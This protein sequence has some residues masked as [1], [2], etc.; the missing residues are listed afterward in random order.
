[1]NATP[2]GLSRRRL[3]WRSAG[4]VTALCLGACDVL[5]SQQISVAAHDWIGYQPL[6]MAQDRGWLDAA[7]VN[8]VPTQH[9]QAS[10]DALRNGQVHAAAL[11]LDEA[12]SLVASQLPVSIVMVFDASMG[13]DVLLV[14]PGIRTLADLKGQRV[15]LENSSL[16][17]IMLTEALQRAQLTSQDITQVMTPYD[18]HEAVWQQRQVDALITF[19]PVATRLQARGMQRLFDSQHIPNTIV[20]VLVLHQRAL[21]YGY[22]S[23]VRHL[24]AG[25]FRAV[26]A[27]RHN[28]QDAAYRLAGR[29]GLPAA[30]VMTAFKGLEMADASRN[31]YLLGGQ[32]PKLLPTAERVAGILKLSDG[33]GLTTRLDR[34]FNASYLPTED[35]MR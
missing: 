11:T 19:E 12:L 22:A 6:F 15:G 16:A 21:G 3:V 34:L 23:A 25:H 27:I 14:R 1:M 28:P 2:H 24:L 4:A 35:L 32:P 33:S 8:L 9:S 7:Q 26:D 29:L 13:A 17:Q 30:A 18:Q 10:I 5:S 20:D 31:F